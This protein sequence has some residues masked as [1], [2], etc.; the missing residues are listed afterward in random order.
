MMYNAY[1]GY[2]GTEMLQSEWNLVPITSTAPLMASNILVTGNYVHKRL[3]WLNQAHTK[4]L[5]ECKVCRNIRVTGNAI[6]YSFEG[7][8]SDGQYGGAFAVPNRNGGDFD[9]PARPSS[10]VHDVEF[11]HNIIRHVGTVVGTGGPLERQL[12]KAWARTW[13]SGTGCGTG[14][15]NAG[16]GINQRSRQLCRRHL[17]FLGGV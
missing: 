7:V 12:G 13:P 16:D 6:E 11:D 15:G 17:C 14:C 4:N 10:Y 2:N 5:V 1:Y 8:N 9:S 3:A